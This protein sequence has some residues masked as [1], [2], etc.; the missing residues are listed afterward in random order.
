VAEAFEKESFTPLEEA[1]MKEAAELGVEFVEFE[2]LDKVN[3]IVPNML[4]AWVESMCGMDMCEA[5]QST[6]ADI[7]SVIGTD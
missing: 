3:E 4:D 1:T 7:R 5:A 6:V 2:D